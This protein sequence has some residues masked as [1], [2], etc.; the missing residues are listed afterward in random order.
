M[1]AKDIAVDG[2]LVAMAL[3]GRRD[4]WLD[5]FLARSARRTDRLLVFLHGMGGNFYRS[6]FKKELTRAGSRYRTDVLM[7]NNRGN[8]G[9]VV[10][11]RFKDCLEDIDTAIAFG[12]RRGYSRFVLM[13][14]STGCQ[15]VTYYQA[16]RQRGDVA[17]VVLAAPADDYAIA[18]RDLGRRYRYW[19]RRARRLV[20]DRKG[21][22]RLPAECN[23][24]SARR[25]ISCA[26]P[27]QIEAG[28]FDY[29]G[30]MNHFRRLRGPVLAFFGDQE[31]FAVLPVDQMGDILRSCALTS[32]FKYF[33]VKGG[34]H[35]FSGREA[36]T[37]RRVYEWLA[38][39]S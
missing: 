30:R 5:G 21:D 34:D 11:E 37:V 20:A 12:K 28:I 23:G 2:S 17:A 24:F 25:F 35:G 10:D 7:F 3:P 39:D 38:R 26:D 22:T 33:T 15:K 31:E 8:T 29:S 6:R 1:S 14:H 27:G 36:H 13:G 16:R 9:D 19:I 4:A 32:R 18:R